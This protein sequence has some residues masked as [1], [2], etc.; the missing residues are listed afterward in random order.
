MNPVERYFRELWEIRSTGAAVPETS[1]YGALETLLN[2]IGTSTKPRVRCVINIEN[3]GAGIPDGGLFTENQ[4]QRP[5]SREP[6]GGQLPERGVIEVKPTSEDAWVTASGR[7]VSRY[8]GKYGLILVTNYRDFVLVGK[9]PQGQPS[10]FE[11]LRLADSEVDFWARIANHKAAASKVGQQLVEYLRRALLHSSPISSPQDVAWF[12]ASYARDSKARIEGVELP[13]LSAVRQSLEDA[14]GVRFE[15]EKGEHFFRSTLI[16]TLFYGIFSAW[17]LW[18]KE[19]TPGHDLIP[20]DWRTAAWSLRLPMIRV[21]F[22]QIATPRLGTIGLVEPLN[23]A[24]GVL[25]RVERPKFFEIFDQGQAVQYF[26]EPFLEQFDPDLRKEL[27]VWYT[28]PQIVKYMIA[29]IDEV[30]R[31]ELGVRDGLADPRVLVLDPCCGT[32]TYLVEVVATIART[33]MKRYGDA[34]APQ[35]IKKAVMERVFGFEILP[36]PFVVAHLQMGIFL[37]HLEAPFLYERAERAPIYLTN[38]LT[39]WVS[40]RESEHRPLFPELEQERSAA[41]GIKRS[42]PILVILGNPP[43]NA[44]AG[45]SSS[46]EDK[47][48]DVYKE[49]LNV[50]ASKGGWGIKK[51]NLDD[52]YVR[53]FRIAERRIVDGKPG[54][55]VICFISNFSF[56]KRDSYVVMR[57]RFFDEFDRLWF[58][59]MN[60]D[61]RETGK[62]TPE[63][64][65]DPSV[66]STEFHPIG[67][68][69][70]TAITLLV[71]KS[72]REKTKLAFYRDFWGINKRSEL[73]HSADVGQ[74]AKPYAELRPS[75]QNRF[76]FAPSKGGGEYETWPKI[77]DLCRIPP[78][79]GLMEKRGGSLIDIDRRSL[80]RRMQ[81]YF[82][83]DI[84]W[85][86][87]V[88]VSGGLTSR[89][90][91]FDPKKARQKVLAVEKYQPDHLVRYALR[92]FDTRWC[93]Y[94][95]TNPLWNRPRPDLWAQYEKENEFLMSRPAGVARPEGIPVYYTKRLGD[96]DFLRGH[97]YYVPLRHYTKESLDA[98][99]F[100]ETQSGS[101]WEPNLSPGTVNYLKE[102]GVTTSHDMS[103]HVWM[104]V[105]AIIF[106]PLYLAENSDGIRRD[107][108]KVP[109]PAS[110]EVLTTSASLGRKIASLL[111]S[112]S[113]DEVTTGQIREELRMVAQITKRGGRPLDLKIGDLDVTA[114]WGHLGMDGAVMPGHGRILERDYHHD[115]LTQ[116]KAGAISL[117]LFEGDVLNLLGNKM[118]DIY[119]NDEVCWKGVPQNVWNF[120]IGGYQ[121]IKKWLSYREKQILGRG[122]SVDEAREVTNMA[123]RIASIILTY[124]SLDENYQRSRKSSVAWA[125]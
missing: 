123:R 69:V 88:R 100:G 106:S 118:L 94:T 65:P 3:R 46:E 9:G 39:G 25:N 2:E 82:D 49:G 84:D 87:F 32:G 21:L 24:S 99:L 92:P 44:F 33:L 59:C 93:Y 58:D 62:L 19:N 125:S 121:A 63:G 110:K 55:G 102:L 71:R 64:Q 16:Q 34:L 78:M 81:Q 95:S 112:E 96:N 6:S 74:S 115:E 13:A 116:L 30:L 97:A 37:Q 22:E 27:G 4:F 119:I 83:P 52:L 113:V 76:L 47:V 51:F 14:L 60:G 66:F 107:W 36:A 68:K 114:D 42:K 1:Y 85:E 7:Q 103:S 28:P 15:G 54:S 75:K 41:E 26:Y 31:N 56:L 57:Q 80:E 67:I 11:T 77:A 45:V 50:P 91:G 8:W 101:D 35:E 111:D 70:G 108:P 43:Y 89:A 79:N 20:F 18:S 124:P 90:A 104:H 109:M 86:T 5:D 122:L 29:R 53:F 38:A 61:S 72:R 40:R 117:G 120:T 105:L 17:V 10:V 23:W 48:V 12:L 98:K 73:L